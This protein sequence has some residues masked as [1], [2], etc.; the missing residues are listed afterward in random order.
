MT[1]RELWYWLTTGVSDA[2]QVIGWSPAD[3]PLSYY[4]H[5]AVAGVVWSVGLLTGLLL[6]TFFGG[7]GHRA[8]AQ[9]EAKWRAR[10]EVA[11]WGFG[12]RRK[13]PPSVTSPT[14]PPGA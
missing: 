5:V 13:Q 3:A 2:W 7:M 6:V 11:Y 12:W 1:P 4:G 9:Q 10:Y 14:S 8:L